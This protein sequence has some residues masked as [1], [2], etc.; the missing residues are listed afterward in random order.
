METID[1]KNKVI[2]MIKPN[3]NIVAMITVN[4]QG[5]ITGGVNCEVELHNNNILVKQ[6]KEVM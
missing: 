4:E 1:C 6:I 2:Q 5:E 3:G